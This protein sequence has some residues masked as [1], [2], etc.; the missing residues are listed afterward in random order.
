V[1]WPWLLLDHDRCE[2][3]GSRG[4]GPMMMSRSASVY[5]DFLLPQLSADTRLLDVGCG[6]GELSIQLAASVGHL[7]GI[8]VDA[9][10]IE[11]ARAAAERAG[12]TNAVFAVGNIVH[13]DQPDEQFD[14]VFG[15]SVLEAM[16]QP[17]TAVAQ[18]H[19]VLRPDGLVAIASVEYG[20]LILAGPHQDLCRRFY[21]IRE[22]LWAIEGSD[23]FLGRHLRGMLRAAGFQQ[24]NATTK[25]ISYGTEDRVTQFGRDRADDC[26][27]AWYSGSAVRHGMATPE[28]LTLMRQA[29]LEWADSPSSYVAF[30][31]CRA[32]GRKSAR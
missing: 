15:H 9:G 18:M 30:A 22:R 12:L 16:A 32:T 7:T 1:F 5:A 4:N 25:T 21:T 23:P 19:R 3:V 20:G 8:D 31:W 2:V 14:V 10:E 11:L 17:Q 27:D 28:E 26:M 24:V 29:W 13:L 6:A